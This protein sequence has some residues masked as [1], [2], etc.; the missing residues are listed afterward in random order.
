ML[1]NIIMF[2]D[3]AT[4][5]N[6]G[7]TVIT[8]YAQDNNICIFYIPKLLKTPRPTFHQQPLELHAYAGDPSLCAVTYIEQYITVTQSIRN[9]ENNFFISYVQPYKPVTSTTIARCV[10]DV[11][12]KS[13]INITTFRAHSTRSAS[14]SKV[15][16]C[17]NLSLKE[18][19]K[20]AGWSN[21]QTFARYYN[22]EI[23]DENFGSSFLNNI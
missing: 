22:K 20:A 17:S 8:V 3:W 16:K 14:S 18:I 11:L 7:C 19:A 21:T 10:T 2:T 5:T 1:C 12:E 9:K 13:G 23:I 6:I 4:I 15:S